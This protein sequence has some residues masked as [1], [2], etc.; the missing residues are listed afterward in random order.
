MKESPGD[1]IARP[2]SFFCDH[3]D[4]LTVSL[5]IAG[6]IQL[7]HLQVNVSTNLWF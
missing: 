3:L 5:L 2:E 6:A 1:E 4:D 7:M